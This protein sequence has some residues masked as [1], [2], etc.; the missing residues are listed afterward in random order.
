MS[1]GVASVLIGL[2]F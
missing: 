1:V 2:T